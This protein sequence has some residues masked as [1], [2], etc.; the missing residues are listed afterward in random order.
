M[1]NKPTSSGANSVLDFILSKVESVDMEVLRYLIGF[2]PFET[3]ERFVYAIAG[4]YNP[5]AMI[6]ALPL[7][8]RPCKNNSDMDYSDATLLSYD[9]LAD[10]VS[11]KWAKTQYCIFKNKEEAEDYEKTGNP[12]PYGNYKYGRTPNEEFPF[13]GKYTRE[14]ESTCSY[15]G[16]VKNATAEEKE[17]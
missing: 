2:L 4:I 13:P 1:Q 5:I 8:S 11:F 14:C 12:K 3:Q 16:W 6:S 17:E 15:S 10:N 7:K 9:Y